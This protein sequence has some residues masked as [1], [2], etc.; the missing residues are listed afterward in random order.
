MW[1]FKNEQDGIGEVRQKEENTSQRNEIKKKK[2]W[3]QKTKNL[4]RISKEII[5]K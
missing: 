2:I 5:C 4:K 3:C 1:V